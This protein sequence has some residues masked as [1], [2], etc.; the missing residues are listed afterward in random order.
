MKKVK[1]G[2][3][4]LYWNKNLGGKGFGFNMA[5]VDK[6]LEDKLNMNKIVNEAEEIHAKINLEEERAKETRVSNLMYDL[7]DKK[8]RDGNKVE[9][10]KV[11]MIKDPN[12]R[13]AMRR[14]ATR[15]ATSAIQNGASYDEV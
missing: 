9:K 6:G 5:E 2:E 14:A 11:K 3:A 13:E 12:I 1:K 7:F 10:E 8:N 15:A 4:K